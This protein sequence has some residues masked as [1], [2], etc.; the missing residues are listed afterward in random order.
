MGNANVTV[1]NITDGGS[2]SFLVTPSANSLTI[3]TATGLVEDKEYQFTVTGIADAATN[4]T[5]VTLQSF[6]TFGASAQAE[7]DAVNAAKASDSTSPSVLAV[8]PDFR[9]PSNQVNQ[10]LRPVI[11]VTFSELMAPS[12]ASSLLLSTTADASTGLPLT[13]EYFDGLTLVVYPTNDLLTGADY[14]VN[15]DLANAV[16]L[17][18]N[19]LHQVSYKFTTFNPIANTNVAPQ[20]LGNNLTTLIE[21]NT[22]PR[23]YFSEPVNVHH[24]IQQFT[25][26]QVLLWVQELRFQVL[27]LQRD[28]MLCLIQM[29]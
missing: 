23:F 14:W 26:S 2:Y 1:T 10:P 22:K 25:S 13:V 9:L 5:T 8:S 27:G 16:D 19:T 18:G 20:H 12:T 29:V 21:R 28:Q 3:S 11:S 24:L 15:F 4:A 6:V 7:I 17:R